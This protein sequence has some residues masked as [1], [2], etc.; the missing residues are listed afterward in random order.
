MRTLSLLALPS[1]AGRMHAEPQT[2]IAAPEVSR[3]KAASPDGNDRTFVAEPI[4]TQW[5]ALHAVPAQVSHSENTFE[6]A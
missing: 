2:T 3:A 6:N 1:L 4:A 5:D